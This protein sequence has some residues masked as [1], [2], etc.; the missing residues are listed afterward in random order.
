MKPNVGDS[1]EIS[2]GERY[3]IHAVHLDGE[4]VKVRTSYGSTGWI[5]VYKYKLIPKYGECLN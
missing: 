5:G 2:T 3:E 4:H 1:I